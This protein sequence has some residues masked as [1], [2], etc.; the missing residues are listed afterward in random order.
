[1]L[2]VNLYI[3]ALQLGLELLKLIEAPSTFV[4][5]AAVLLSTAVK[6]NQ[7]HIKSPHLLRL[8]RRYFIWRR[9][10]RGMT[11]CGICLVDLGGIEPP[12]EQLILGH[13]KISYSSTSS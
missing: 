6:S 5:S 11:V 7:A 12:S 1:M 2:P 13:A 3:E 9:V 4:H 10:H 8:S